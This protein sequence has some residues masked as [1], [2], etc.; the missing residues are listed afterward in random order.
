MLQEPMAQFEGACEGRVI[1]WK[2]IA[3]VL[4][5]IPFLD[6]GF[7]KRL[8]TM[9]TVFGTLGRSGERSTEMDLQ[10]IAPRA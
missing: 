4:Y 1:D 6:V 8:I 9:D 2:D 3:E 10:A 5:K 7:R